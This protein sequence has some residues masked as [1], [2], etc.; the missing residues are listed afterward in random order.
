MY[1]LAGAPS[2]VLS[3]AQTEC[4]R[5]TTAVLVKCY[6]P[7]RVATRLVLMVGCLTAAATSRARMYTLAG[8][9]SSVLSPAQTEC[10]RDTTAVVPAAMYLLELQHVWY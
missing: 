8:A 9:P 4:G 7:A 1:T 5:D 6:V 3:P 10:G 2:S